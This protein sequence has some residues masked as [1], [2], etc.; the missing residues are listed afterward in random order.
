M[1]I[2]TVEKYATEFQVLLSN[3]GS[4]VVKIH[5]DQFHHLLRSTRVDEAEH[6]RSSELIRNNDAKQT[7][8]LCFS[9]DK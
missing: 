3:R 1:F 4:Q 7:Q 6:M 5:I 2:E 8:L 9:E